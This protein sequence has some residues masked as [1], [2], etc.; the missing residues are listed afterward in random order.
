[1]A[2]KRSSSRRGGSFK[3]VFWFNVTLAALLGGWYFFQPPARQAEVRHLVGNY[4]EGNKQVQLADVAWDIYQLYY[5][6]DY[7]DAVASGDRTS[8]YG[9]T[10][11]FA[12]TSTPVRV[13][14]NTG[15]IVGYA[16]ALATPLWA[17]YRVKDLSPLPQAAER[18][19]N[20]DTDTRT[21]ARISSQDYTGSG[22]D[23]GHLAPNYAI[24]TRYGEAAQRGTFVMSN[25]IP[26]KHALN[27]GLWKDLEMKIATSYPARF[28]EVWVIAGPVFKKPSPT[29][30]RSRVP[31]PEACYM[32]VIDE[33]DGR[34]R[35]TAYLFPQ[36]AKG[37]LD[38]YLVSIDEIEA[39]TGLDFLTE[40]PAE[41]QAQLETKRASRAW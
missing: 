4:F 30:P 25:V 38:N 6:A 32:L 21:I 40:F 35:S 11:K 10:P 8:L 29:L 14:V 41:V 3:F 15:Y 34:V 7:V 33:S 17:A 24:A 19:D 20:F 5:S 37:S 23:R 28:A 16:D 39:R 12:Q 2:R 31:I 1:M 27:A 26:Q 36:D 13:L 9:G 22:Y 18:P